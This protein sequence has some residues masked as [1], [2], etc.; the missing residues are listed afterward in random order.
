MHKYLYSGVNKSLVYPEIFVKKIVYIV[1]TP[2]WFIKLVV[3][4]MKVRY[5]HSYQT[6]TRADELVK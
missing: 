4:V 6:S 2:V 3:I 5:L 1:Y